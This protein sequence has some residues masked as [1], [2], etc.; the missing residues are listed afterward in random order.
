MWPG[1]FTG[2]LW[3]IGAPL[4][5]LV[6]ACTV[7]LSLGYSAGKAKVQR[8][9]DAANQQALEQQQRENL[10]R[11]EANH[12]NGIDYRKLAQQSAVSAALARADAD[13]V[14]G[15]LAARAASADAGAGFGSHEA[16]ATARSL[17]E[18]IGEYQAVAERHDRLSD[19]VTGLQGFVT[20]V[21]LAP[22]SQ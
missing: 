2:L 4:L 9:W 16:A 21:C 20:R 22:P 13:S 15:E 10:R 11:L 17:G 7:L 19:Q 3:R 14:R 18:C 1:L 12:G 5:A 6:A 8:A